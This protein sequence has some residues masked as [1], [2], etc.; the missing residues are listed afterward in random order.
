MNEP[1]PPLLPTASLSGTHE[2]TNEGDDKSVKAGQTI[3]L[4]DSNILQPQPPLDS[5]CNSS[6][7]AAVLENQQSVPSQ[8]SSASFNSLN[9]IHTWLHQTLSP[10]ESPTATPPSPEHVQINHSKRKRSPS[11]EF[12]P[13]QLS[14]T[15]PLT[16]KA[17]KQHFL[18]TMS[19]D[20]ST[21][22]NVRTIHL[23][24]TF[25]VAHFSLANLHSD[26]ECVNER[27]ITS[28]SRH[29]HESL[30]NL[31]PK[32]ATQRCPLLHGGPSDVFR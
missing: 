31:G 5:A 20:P 32:S 6:H 27:L 16:R 2:G 30:Q 12:G 29:S 8:P 19:S 11:P 10:T 18:S 26:K 3:R 25:Q 24:L 1:T 4:Q 14:P 22:P 13:L 17:L 21:V 23:T 15:V 28:N 7:P 9:S